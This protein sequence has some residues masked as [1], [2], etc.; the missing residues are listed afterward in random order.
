MEIRDL[1][2]FTDYYKNL[3]KSLDN[4]DK[5]QLREVL[6]VLREVRDKNGKVYLMGNGGSAAT[7]SH[8]A[9]DLIKFAKLRCFPILDTSVIT[10]MAND[11]PDHY[12]S[13]F[14]K[15]LQV[16]LDPEKSPHDVVIAITGSGNS[17]NIIKAL[18]FAREN[19]IKTVGFLGFDGGQ[20][21]QLCDCH[22]LINV[23]DNVIDKQMAYGIIEDL[24]LSLLGH[25]LAKILNQR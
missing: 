14:K 10:A 1:E 7:A 21:K 2:I 17:P 19:K 20:A 15:Q 11:E 24:H 22:I 16:L 9:N 3:L 4:I 5:N 13:I 18:Q 12:E 8:V 25:S 6:L 23:P